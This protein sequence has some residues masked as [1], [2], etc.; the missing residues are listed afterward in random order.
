M[1]KVIIDGSWCLHRAFHVFSRFEYN[2]VKT[3]TMYGLLRDVFLLADQF[4]TTDI[5]ICWDSHSFRKELNADYKA[6]RIKPT[7]PSPY[8]NL[9]EIQDILAATGISQWY[10]EGYEADDLIYT[11]CKT[12][13]THN[14]IVIFGAD[15]DLYQCLDTNVSVLREHRKDLYHIHDFEEE[16]K[17]PFNADSFILWKSIVGDGS[18]NIKGIMRFPKKEIQAYLS[19]KEMNPR[20]KKLFDEGKD[21][22]KKNEEIFKLHVVENP[23]VRKGKIDINMIKYSRTNYGIKNVWLHNGAKVMGIGVEPK[24]KTVRIKL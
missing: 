4:K 17:F 12:S 16:F 11:I 15:K 3:G 2:G 20:G 24:V 7:G 19:G 18:D 10:A 1:T 5:N 23:E 9:S 22:I 6:N 21:I 13:S 8:D 14:D